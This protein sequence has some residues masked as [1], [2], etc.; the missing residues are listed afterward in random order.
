MKN[1]YRVGSRDS[2]LAIAQTKIFIQ[3]VTACTSDIEFVIAPI[4]SEGD[5]KQTLSLAE[6]GGKGLFVNELNNAILDGSIDIA[7]HSLKDLPFELPPGL[8]ITWYSARE[9]PRDV[10]ILPKGAGYDLTY[11]TNAN[12]NSGANS[13]ANTKGKVSGGGASIGTS[14]ARRACF[15]KELYPQCRCLPIRGNVLTR[16]KK[17]DAFECNALV[18][19][20]AAVKRLGLEERAAKYFST[21]E[22]LPAAS[23]AVLCA[24]TARTG[25]GAA[26]FLAQALSKCTDRDAELAARAERSF[27]K[28]FSADCKSPVAAYCEITNDSLMLRCA[29]FNNDNIRF[30]A[31]LTG[32]RD[33]AEELEMR[34]AK[35]I[36][37]N[38]KENTTNNTA[39][40]DMATINIRG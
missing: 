8:N 13:G 2:A 11:I 34:A 12:A 18:L 24:V 3:C 21:D 14:S 7:V 6:Y 39:K 38:I 37:E 33:N 25:K 35:I 23:Q 28:H 5:K 40:N 9:D 4:K 20:A 26:D 19:A 22:M 17:L 16:L 32:S 27:L 1:I 10:L 36:L 31:K 29:Y 30:D 15:I